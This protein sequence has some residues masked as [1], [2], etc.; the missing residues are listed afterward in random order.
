MHN[1]RCDIVDDVPVPD[2]MPSGACKGARSGDVH[3]NSS[4]ETSQQPTKSGGQ[5]SFFQLPTNEK[6]H[7]GDNHLRM[8]LW[9]S[10]DVRAK[11]CLA[12]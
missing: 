2:E 4:F 12:P 11:S 9:K 3:Y 8:A 10:A 6:N 7:R 1:A 5:V